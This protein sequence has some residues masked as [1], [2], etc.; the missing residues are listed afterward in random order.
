M[1]KVHD[2]TIWIDGAGIAKATN[3]PLAKPGDNVN[4]INTTTA[5]A[6]VFFP[7]GGVFGSGSGH[8]HHQIKDGDSFKPARAV[9][10]QSTRKRTCRYAIWCEETHAF[11]IGNSDPEI[12]VET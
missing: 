8:F 2:V 11:A 6:I 5:K 9:V 4:W 3:V 7:H 1:A 10:R 12:I